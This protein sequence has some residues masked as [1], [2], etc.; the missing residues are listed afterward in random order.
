METET[1]KVVKSKAAS[2]DKE[3]WYRFSLQEQQETPKRLEDAAK[4]LASMISISLSIFLSVAGK[5]G[6]SNLVSSFGVILALIFW[7]I[8]LLTSF[9]VLFPF[10]YK[11]STDSVKSFQK[12]HQKIVKVKRILLTVSLVFFSLALIILGVLFLLK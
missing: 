2:P 12:T 9:F 4:F 8:S 7:I 3:I 10:R 6:L 11:F 1:P 5:D